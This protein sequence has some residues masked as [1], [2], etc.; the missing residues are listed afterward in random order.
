[1]VQKHPPLYSISRTPQTPSI[2]LAIR[3]YCRTQNQATTPS[4]HHSVSGFLTLKAAAVG[5]YYVP[6]LLFYLLSFYYIHSHKG[7]F[8]VSIQRNRGFHN[9]PCDLQV[10]YG[11]GK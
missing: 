10:G 9:I 8:T 5:A 6:P 4:H 3:F 2:H 1:M 11:V 7:V